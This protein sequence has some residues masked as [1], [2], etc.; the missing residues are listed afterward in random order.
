MVLVVKKPPVSSHEK[1]EKRYSSIKG[2]LGDLGARKLAIRVP[3][4]D[5]SLV[6]GNSE[7]VRKH[8]VVP[9]IL[10]VIFDRFVRLRIFQ[11]DGLGE[12]QVLGLISGVGREEELS[13][14]VRFAEPGLDVFFL[15][16]SSFLST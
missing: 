14:V 11:V 3:K 8:T 1:V 15:T 4:L 9:G 10:D 13:D 12:D 2:Q 6:V 7:F 16:Y 5:D